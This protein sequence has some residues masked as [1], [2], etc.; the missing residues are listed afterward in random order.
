M[1]TT[2]EGTQRD[3]LADEIAGH[4]IGSGYEAASVGMDEAREIAE[5][6]L[7]AGYRKPRTITTVEGLDALPAGSVIRAD[8]GEVFEK[9]TDGPYCDG[10]HD[11][12][13]FEGTFWNGETFVFPVAILHEPEPEVGA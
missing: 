10:P 13:S 4:P 7:A 9:Q 5:T 1:T 6:I 3:E 12:Q 11:W 2:N 8:N